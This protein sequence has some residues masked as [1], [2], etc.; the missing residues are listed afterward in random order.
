M[1]NLYVSGTFA[2]YKPV[3]VTPVFTRDDPAAVPPMGM[4][5]EGAGADAPVGAGA[6]ES[7]ALRLIKTVRLPICKHP[8]RDLHRSPGAPAAL[9]YQRSLANECLTPI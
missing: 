4:V 9:T 5:F 8:Y 7:A 2:R 3:R 1:K 6:D